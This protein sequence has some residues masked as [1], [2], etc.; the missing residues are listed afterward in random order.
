MESIVGL[1]GKRCEARALL[2]PSWKEWEEGL[3][4][5]DVSFPWE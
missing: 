3:Q 2:P 1:S 4:A 5:E